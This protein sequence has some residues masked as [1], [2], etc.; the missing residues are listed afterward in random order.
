V[1]LVHAYSQERGLPRRQFLYL[2]IGSTIGIV[3]GLPTIHYGMALKLFPTVRWDLGFLF[4]L[5]P[6]P[7]CDFVGEN[8]RSTLKKDFPILLCCYGFP[9]RFIRV[10]YLP[11]NGFLGIIP[12]VWFWSYSLT[13]FIGNPSWVLPANWQAHYP[14]KQKPTPKSWVKIGFK[15]I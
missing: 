7:Y 8:F 5:W 15:L 6:I 4:Q 2:L 14:L 13:M 12:N 1:L 3:G 11:N 9:S 10:F